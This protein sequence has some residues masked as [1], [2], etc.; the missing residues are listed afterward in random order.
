MI[1]ITEKE[2]HKVPGITSLFVKFDYHPNIVEAIKA[3]GNANY[4]KKTQTW[5]IPL[6]KLSALVDS[7]CL[8]DSIDLTFQ[9][10]VDTPQIEEPLDITKF[11]TTP[12]PYQIEGIQYG[13]THPNWLLLDAPGL[14]KT[15]QIIY[16]AQELKQRENIEHCFIVCGINTLKSNWKKEIQKHSDLDCV[17][18]GERVN[19]KGKTIIG[20]VAERATQLKEHID[21]FFVITNIETIRDPRIVEA[22][23]HSVNKFDMIAFD[24]VHTCKSPTAQQS[25][26]MLKLDAKYKIAM[27]GTLLLNNPLDAYMPLKW[28]GADRS[29]YSNFKY[30]Y[31]VFDGP[32][33]NQITG[34]KNTKFLKAQIETCS[35]RRTKDLLDLPEKN[36]IHEFVD[37]NDDQRKFYDNIRKGII[38]QVDKVHM[39][40]ASLLAMIT[41]L[42]QA[43]ACPSSLSSEPISSAKIERCVDLVN[44]LVEQGEKVVIFSVFKETLNQL[45]EQLFKYKPFL[46]TGDIP[47]AIISSNIDKFQTDNEHQVMLATTA[48][49]GTGI[50]LTRASYAIFIDTPWTAGACEQCEDRIHRIGSSA[51]V[52]IY[53]LWCN[54]TIDTRVKTIVEDKSIISDYMIDNSVSEKFVDRL[55]N[56]IEDI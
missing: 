14:G 17:I 41:R 36:I 23:K 22:F 37:M 16:L 20:S 11:K 50:T 31:C 13:L 53:Y 28:I 25:K 9:E 39:S 48:K 54:D 52:F 55:R 12:Y 49:M 1:Y 24:E 42:R 30:F 32:F 27:T 18:L 26:N 10:Q 38:D 47:D 56:L 2:T 4:D 45:Q 7:L 21:E 44:Q 15:L 35:L 33:N 29:T 6:I 46:C 19:T 34:F 5:E 3:I 43:T 8:F 51:P 40:T